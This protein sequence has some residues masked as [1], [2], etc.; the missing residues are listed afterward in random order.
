MGWGCR[1]CNYDKCS[2]CYRP[3]RAAPAVLARNVRNYCD[4]QGW[5]VLHYACRLGYP[6]VV[7]RLLESR[8]DVDAVDSVHDYT[9]LMVAA[10]HGQAEVFA[11]LLSKGASP[12]RVNMQGRSALDCARRWGHAD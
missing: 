2:K 5:S 1:A 9:P 7:A 3:S 11:M 6:Q 12:E 8:V 10:T 4:G